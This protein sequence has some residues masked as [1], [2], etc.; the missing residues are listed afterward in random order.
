M[1]DSLALA[2]RANYVAYFRQFA[3]HHHGEL[4]LGDDVTWFAAGG[5]PGTHI[6]ATAFTANNADTRIQETLAELSSRAGAIVWHLF[7]TCTPADLG[8]RLARA[9]FQH[10][11]GEPWM[12]AEISA[13]QPSPVPPG[14]EICTVLDSEMLEQWTLASAVGYGMPVSAMRIWSDTYASAGLNAD[15]HSLHFVARA[16]PEAVA[17]STLLLTETMAG[18]FDVATAPAFRGSGNGSAITWAAI[19]AARDRGYRH[20]CLQATKQGVRLY[21]RMGFRTVFQPAEYIWRRRSR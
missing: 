6:L 13:L 11:A 5:A 10:Y 7:E 16:G 1:S 21:Q 20:I 18:V 19:D 17:A 9:G 3:D 12:V 2:M 4:Y 14:I 8:N 15:S